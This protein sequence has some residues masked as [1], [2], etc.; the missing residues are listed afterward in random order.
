VLKK[1]PSKNNKDTLPNNKQLKIPKYPTLAPAGSLD[2]IQVL[3]QRRD[4][5][6]DLWHPLDNPRMTNEIRVS[7]YR[8]NKIERIGQLPIRERNRTNAKKSRTKK[9]PK[10]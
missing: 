10:T 5:G 1:F 6:E 9:L 3:I 4:N 7:G 2:K 8:S